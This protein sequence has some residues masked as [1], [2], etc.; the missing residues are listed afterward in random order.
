[1]RAVLLASV[2]LVG[3]TSAPDVDDTATL[4]APNFGAG[5]GGSI[6]PS[7]IICPPDVTPVARYR[8]DGSLTDAMGSSNTF[9]QE[10]GSSGPP[11]YSPS[12]HGQAASFSSGVGVSTNV[13]AIRNSTKYTLAVWARFD[14]PPATTSLV[15]GG[16]CQ[17]YG[18]SRA[19]E[20][21]MRFYLGS[22]VTSTCYNPVTTTYYLVL[23]KLYLPFPTVGT[24]NHYAAT[25]DG[26]VGRAYVN[27]VYV[28]DPNMPYNNYYS[29]LT[30]GDVVGEVG[31]SMFNGEVDELRTYDTALTD[32][33]IANLYTYNSTVNPFACRDPYPL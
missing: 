24:W 27:G 18:G 11:T 26:S 1:M 21:Y 25:Y 22:Y 7:A 3:C 30:I 12:P 20:S 17:F 23:G 4:V 16:E 19:V 32:V 5:G 28:G 33:Q 9:A 14:S 15:T 31:M 2:V 10:A 29:S 8:F 6:H 13:G